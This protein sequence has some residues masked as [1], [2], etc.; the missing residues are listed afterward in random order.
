[1][2]ML[3]KN[4][5]LDEIRQQYVLTARAKGLAQRRVLWKHVFRNALLPLVTGLPAA[6]IAAFFTGSLLIETLFS[7]DGLGLLSFE[8]II[9]R[10][11]PVVLGTLYLFTLIGL[12]VKLIGD[13]ATCSSIRASA[14]MSPDDRDRRSAHPCVAR[15]GACG[16]AS[17]GIVWASGRCSSSSCCWWSAPSARSLCNDKPLVVRYDG[18][19]VFPLAARPTPSRFGGDFR[20]APTTTIRSSASSSA[21]PATSRSTRPTL[22]LRHART[23]SRRRRTRPAL[24]A[25][26]ARH[27]PSGCDVSLGFCTAFGVGVCSRSR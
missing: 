24:A 17:S 26:L 19:L 13:V 25:E 23:T 21:S 18:A 8:S 20:H 5:F 4:T 22:L 3:T 2:T 12:L 16:T 10:D 15:R 7:L 14:S 11:Y 9:R 6:F 27:R 1:M